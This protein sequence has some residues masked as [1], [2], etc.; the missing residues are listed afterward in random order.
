MGAEL[1]SSTLHRREQAGERDMR[2]LSEHAGVVPVEHPKYGPVS[3]P[4]RRP[5]VERI[6]SAK[7]RRDASQTKGLR[8]V[9]LTRHQWYDRQGVFRRG[10]ARQ[11]LS[12]KVADATRAPAI[13]ESRQ[14]VS[15]LGESTDVDEPPFRSHARDRHEQLG[16]LGRH[17]LEPFPLA[18]GDGQHHL[19]LTVGPQAFALEG[20]AGE[21]PPGNRQLVRGSLHDEAWGQRK[22]TGPCRGLG[23][24]RSSEARPD[25]HGVLPC[26]ALPGRSRR[27]GASGRPGGTT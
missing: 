15:E 2:G 19:L 10:D 20:P 12:A 16:D 22:A 9:H 6:V 5:W 23:R 4:P 17:L 26:A 3:I 8:S 14:R 7:P 13:G 11:V 25:S 21:R 24:S 1:A 18:S 27:D